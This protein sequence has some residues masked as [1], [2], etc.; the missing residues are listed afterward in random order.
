[1]NGRSLINTTLSSS[2]WSGGRISNVW[3]GAA[4][5]QR[6]RARPQ[7]SGKVGQGLDQKE[8]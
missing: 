7:E 2:K 6:L 3:G 4:G 8:S 5:N 1:M